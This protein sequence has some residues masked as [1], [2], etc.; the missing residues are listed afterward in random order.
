MTVLILGYYVIPAQVGIFQAAEQVSMLPAIVLISFNAIFIPMI[1]GYY[2]QGEMGRLNEMFKI[3][4]KWS[5]YLSLPLLVVIL[6]YPSR[7]LGIVYGANYGNGT[8]VLLVIIF[9]QLINAAT[10]SVAPLLGMTGRQNRLLFM[11]G[12]SFIICGGLNVWLIPR[13]GSMGAAVSL[14]GGIILLNLLLLWDVRRSLGLWPYDWRYY[15]M[16]IAAAITAAVTFMFSHIW[17]TPPLWGL[18]LVVVIS[19]GIFA[20]VLLAL[21]LEHYELDLISSLVRNLSGNNPKPK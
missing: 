19:L 7:V 21:R 5:L 11:T 12:I 15:K 3:G 2:Q 10:G 9:A 20:A 1:V 6:F 13:F 14:G 18:I 8:L 17:S 16:L 4:T